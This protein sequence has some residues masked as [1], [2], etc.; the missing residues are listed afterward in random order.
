MIF[1]LALSLWEFSGNIN[2][3]CGFYFALVIQPLR[4]PSAVSSLC[5][6]TDGYLWWKSELGLWCSAVLSLSY[7]LFTGVFPYNEMGNLLLE[8]QDYEKKKDLKKET[9]RYPLYYTLIY[10]LY[11]QLIIQYFSSFF[12]FGGF[13]FIYFRLLLLRK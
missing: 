5:C 8:K 13:V 7:F 11:I 1:G 10:I 12:L 4:T 9:Y 6:P 2:V 3:N